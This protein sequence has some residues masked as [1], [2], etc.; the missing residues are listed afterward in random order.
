M[1]AII[2]A[3]GEGKRLRPLTNDKPKCMVNLFGRNLLD[4]K[5][6]I[7][8]KCG[9]SEIIVVTGYKNEKINTKNVKFYKNT[10]F[11]KTNM[12]ETLFCARKEFNDTL[13]VIY[14][15]IIFEKKILQKLLE[16]TDEISVIVDENW[17]DYWNLRF[18]NPLDDAESLKIDKCGFIQNIGQ[19][20]NSIEEICGQ[21]IGLIKF[22]KNIINKITEFYDEMKKNSKI[23]YNPLN[24]KLPFEK[25]Y[26]TD[27]LQKMIDSGFKIKSIPIKNGWLELDSFNDFQIYQKMNESGQIKN[28]FNVN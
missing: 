21:Y 9:I 18:E 5:I 26:M 1:K 2:L 16:N 27:F 23:N 17:K 13:I 24:S 6:D 25:S 14:G 8:K 10:K 3:A 20:V 22:D 11:D 15:D 7:L 12:V 28:F 4:W 19:K